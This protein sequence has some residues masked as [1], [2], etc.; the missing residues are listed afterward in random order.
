MNV[1][2]PRSTPPPAR[3]YRVDGC[4]KTNDFALLWETLCVCVVAESECP[5]LINRLAEE[6]PFPE[7]VRA[8]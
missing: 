1:Y 2:T 3:Y 7:K 8:L 6:R 5:F 4:E